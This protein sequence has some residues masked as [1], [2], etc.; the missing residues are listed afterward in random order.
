MP[1]IM[2]FVRFVA[3]P[4]AVYTALTTPQGVRAWWTADGDLDASVGDAGEFRFYNSK[5]IMRIHIDELTPPMR[6][7]W[8]STPF[9]LSGSEPRSPSNCDPP[10]AGLNCY[11]PNAVIRKRTKIKLFCTTGWGIY[12]A[13][14]Q[15]HLEAGR[16]EER[17]A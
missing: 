4:A 17:T 13:R 10:V 2:H 6:V 15:Q 1:D 16:K 3:E 8:S 11:S 7:V 14:L 12:F 5:K 9:D